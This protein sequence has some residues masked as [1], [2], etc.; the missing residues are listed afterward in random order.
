M[1]KTGSSALGR[2]R[3]AFYLLSLALLLVAFLG[4]Q[5]VGNASLPGSR[6]TN[7]PDIPLPTQNAEFVTATPESG[8]LASPTAAGRLLGIQPPRFF[9]SETP[10]GSP[11]PFPLLVNQRGETIPVTWGKYPGPSS[12][13]SVPI[14]PPVGIIPLPDGQINILLLGNDY[15]RKLGAR[16]DTILLLTLNPDAGTASVTSFP[17]D[18]YVYAPGYSM[19]KINA[20]QPTGGYELLKTAFEYNF[21]VRPDYHVNI[22]MEAFIK[23]IDT[24]GGIRVYVTKPLSDP[25]FAGGKYSVGEGWI[26]MNGKTAKWYVQSRATSSD[27]DRAERQQAVLEAIFKRL[28]S[29]DGLN[30]ASELYNL[31]HRY[32]VTDIQLEDLLPLIPLAAQLSD[33][34]RVE[35]Y[36]I[37]PGMVQVV[38]LPVSGAYV[39]IPDQIKVL[40]LMLQALEP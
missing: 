36:A 2:L 22:G 9:A 13:P 26:T 25:S 20:I 23:V 17:R 31:Y 21:G 33:T 28:L 37:K 5:A 15:R 40:E 8:A 4:L 7:T 27:F 35:R 3:N 19:M 39:L 32:V 10:A 34:S 16:T 14:P 29:L 38:R 12:W 6:A 11:T 18:L 1:R 30:R 24:L